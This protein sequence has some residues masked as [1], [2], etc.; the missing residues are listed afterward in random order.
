[1]G[2]PACQV[3]VGGATARQSLA[4]DISADFFEVPTDKLTASHGTTRMP[5]TGL[6]AAR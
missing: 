6:D 5:R 1:M 2:S 4:R 3:P